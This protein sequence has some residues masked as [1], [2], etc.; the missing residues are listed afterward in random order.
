MYVVSLNTENRIVDVYDTEQLVD[1]GV[2]TFPISEQDFQQVW[3]SGRNGNWVYQNGVVTHD[4][5]P[6]PEP[7]TPPTTAGM[8]SGTMPQSIL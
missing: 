6:E 8:P 3:A 2:E 4:P 7:Y 1:E 5:L